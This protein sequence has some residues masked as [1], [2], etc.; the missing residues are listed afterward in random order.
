MTCVCALPNVH[1]FL[2][3]KASDYDEDHHTLPNAC[4]FLQYLQGQ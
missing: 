1:I 4:I 2:Q 3:Y